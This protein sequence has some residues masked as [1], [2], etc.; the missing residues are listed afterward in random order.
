M[1]VV[2]TSV[3][4]DYFNGQATRQTDRLDRLLGIEPVGIGDLIL[5]ETLQ[6]FRRDEDFARA[7]KLLL[8]LALFEM[9]GAERAIRSADYFRTLRKRGVAVRKTSDVI[10]ASYCVDEGHALLFSDRD[11]R[12]FVDHFDLRAV[13]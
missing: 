11:F 13:I 6:G 5:A 3:W 7:K 12:P 2:D 9:L 10:I 1:I 8:S 4:V